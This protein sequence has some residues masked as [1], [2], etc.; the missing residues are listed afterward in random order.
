MPDSEL[1][2]TLLDLVA[3][4]RKLARVAKQ[5]AAPTLAAT[6]DEVAN[7]YEAKLAALNAGSDPLTVISLGRLRLVS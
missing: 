1:R 5:A 4:Y 6:Y 3:G 7:L 2:Q